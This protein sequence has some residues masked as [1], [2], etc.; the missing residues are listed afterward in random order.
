MEDNVLEL[1][2]ISKGFRSKKGVKRVL[3]DI[4]FKFR[5]GENMAILGGNG[6]GKST[7]A[8]MICG[9]ELPDSGQ[10]HRQGTVS[11]PLGFAGAISPNMTGRDNVRFVARIYGANVA[12][13]ERFVY[14]FSELGRAYDLPVVT[15]AN[16]MRARLSY[17][18]SM[19]LKFDVYV[20]DEMVAV[21]DPAFKRK[22]LEI[23]A[24]RSKDATVIIVSSVTTSPAR[25]CSVGMIL[26]DGK[27]SEVAPL[28]DTIAR[29][30]AVPQEAAAAV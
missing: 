24:E 27:L 29:Y 7:L 1:R 25:F 20:V 15:Y 18:I 19:A 9:M 10:V 30:S 8:R 16:S 3:N 5:E 11:F 26:Q 6:S 12:Q 21:G 23:F 2:H 28:K 14:E 22:C 4:S 13:V 17:G